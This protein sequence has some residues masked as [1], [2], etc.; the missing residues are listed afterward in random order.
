MAEILASVDD[1]NANLP[2]DDDVPTVVADD[3]NT[4]LIQ[5]S[6]ARM[7]RG[8]LSRMVDNATLLTWVTPDTTPEIV[9]EVAAKLIASQLFIN[10]TS[11]TTTDI[12]D[13]SFAQ[14][15]YDEAISILQQII[16]GDILIPGV[17]TDATG[18]MSVEDFFP[19]DGT[20]RAFT[21]GQNF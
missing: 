2:S 20:D 7:V 6:V 18:D 9:T 11:K 12:E 4:R 17:T 19:I 13:K 1:V 8:Y 5:I 10:K 21:M 3:D 15:K 14:R 16:T